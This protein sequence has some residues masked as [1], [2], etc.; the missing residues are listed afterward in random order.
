[1]L[2]KVTMKQ[3]HVVQEK[4]QTLQEQKTNAEQMFGNMKKIILMRKNGLSRVQIT[5]ITIQFQSAMVFI[6]TSVV[7]KQ[8]EELI[9][10]FGISMVARLK[11]LKFQN[12]IKSGPEFQIRIKT[13]FKTCRAPGYCQLLLLQFVVL[14][15]TLL[16][17]FRVFLMR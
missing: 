11:S 1:M 13:Y 10:M 17:F 6:Q 12:K 5:V 8:E 3:K 14:L 7:P 15:R 2:V 9:F 16:L 4:F